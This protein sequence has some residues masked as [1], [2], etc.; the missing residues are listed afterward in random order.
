MTYL[1]V[2]LAATVPADP[3]QPTPVPQTPRPRPVDDPARLIARLGQRHPGT[4]VTVRLDRT[5]C[6]IHL[7]EYGATRM[8]AKAA[9]LR[10]AVAAL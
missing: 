4:P 5:G 7:H 10:H 1:E 3:R 8:L 9:T 2:A 6:T